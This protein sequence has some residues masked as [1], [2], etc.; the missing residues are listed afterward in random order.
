[1]RRESSFSVI[2]SHISGWTAMRIDFLKLAFLIY[3][4]FKY[5]KDNSFALL[6][7]SNISHFTERL[8]FILQKSVEIHFNGSDELEKRVKTLLSCILP[9]MQSTLGSYFLL[10]APCQTSGRE[11]SHSLAKWL[12]LCL[13][14]FIG[15]RV[16]V[17][18]SYSQI[19]DSQKPSF[20]NHCIL[21]RGKENSPKQK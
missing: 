13:E 3:K 14:T 5:F 6:L 15:P 20:G 2:F 7:P 9:L 18:Y 16:I 21:L 4:L 19:N 17:S 11:P 8:I 1:M 10:S 12:L